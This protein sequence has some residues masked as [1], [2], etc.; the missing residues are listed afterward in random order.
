V[1]QRR[2]I[3]WAL[4]LIAIGV[5][6]LLREAGVLPRDV[7]WWPIVVFGL[8]LWL[9]VERAFGRRRDGGDLVLPL[10]LMA[11]GV[12][13]FLRDAGVVS[14]SADLW[15]VVLI[16]IGVGIALSAIPI[17]HRDE[18][19][20]R[21][22]VPLQGASAGRIAIRHGAGRLSVRATL[23]P[24]VLVDG[25][26]GG[27]VRV[28][29]RRRGDELEVTLEPRGRRFGSPEWE[30]GLARSVPL[31]LRV[32]GGANRADLDLADLRIDRL[33]VET[34]ASQTSITMP[35]AGRPR[36]TVR[37]GAARVDIRIPERVP[38]RIV[39]HAELAGVRVDE[40]RFPR[41]DGGYRSPGFDETGDGV[42]LTIE[43]GAVSVEI[44]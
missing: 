12:V 39:S 5:V 20:E 6:L 27:G 10:V 26:F 7:E 13:F 21:A 22:S 15:P 1:N 42:D 11:V 2:S 34:G 18:V 33:D 16:A 30:V 44:R 37:C 32:E 40:R 31:S 25:S 9:L 3:V 24:A 41:A 19:V 17:G 29:E 28:R 36:A 8:G 14:D 38:A 4:L 23:D 43:G 35:S